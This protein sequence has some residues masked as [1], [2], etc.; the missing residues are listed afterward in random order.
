M[1][2]TLNW[3]KDY[4]DFD[5]SAADLSQRLTMVGLE[6]D[7]M[8]HL[9]EGLDGVIVARLADVQP[10][11]DAERL[12]VCKVETGSVTQQ[13]VCGARLNQTGD[14][15]A[16]PG[17]PGGY[18]TLVRIDAPGAWEL[19]LDVRQD[20]LRFVHASRLTIPAGPAI[21]EGGSR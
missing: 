18:R 21:P 3:L 15:V 13:V 1:K 7:A 5:L 10:H 6:V 2:V 8:E 19:R 17:A 16:L 9:G 12:T 14:L 11:P 20:S 4:V